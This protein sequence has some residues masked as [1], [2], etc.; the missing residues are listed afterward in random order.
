[1]PTEAPVGKT[2]AEPCGISHSLHFDLFQSFALGGRK[3]KAPENCRTEAVNLVPFAYFTQEHCPLEFHLFLLAV[4]GLRSK[5][6]FNLIRKSSF[7]MNKSL[8]YVKQKARKN[9][10]TYF[11]AASIF[12]H[13]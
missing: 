10:E 13:S 1:M 6:L 5:H 12:I 2:A 4:F 11:G 8:D 7:D 3:A 9:L